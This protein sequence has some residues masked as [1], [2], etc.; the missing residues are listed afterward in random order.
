[1]PVYFSRRRKTRA[2]PARTEEVQNRDFSPTSITAAPFYAPAWGASQ[3][4]Q[5]AFSGA[6]AKLS[7][8][9]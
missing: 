9:A 6:S 2:D 8:F 5:G 3:G 7:G 1:M 4:Y